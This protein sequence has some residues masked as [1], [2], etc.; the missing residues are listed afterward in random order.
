[1]DG[2]PDSPAGGEDSVRATGADDT[3]TAG[4]GNVGHVMDQRSEPD[5]VAPWVSP[6]EPIVGSVPTSARPVAVRAD[7][8]PEIPTFRLP[9]PTGPALRSPVP[10]VAPEARRRRRWPIAVAGVAAI[11]ALVGAGVIGGLVAGSG[12]DDGGRSVV[13]TADRDPISVAAPVVP[14]EGGVIGIGDTD[15]AAIARA[16]APSVVT[17]TSLDGDQPVGVG[18]GVVVSADGE[19]VTNAHVIAG[20]SDVRVR[21]QGATEPRDATVI[22][23]DPANDVALIRIDPADLDEPLAPA[24][25][26]EPGSLAVGQPVVAIGY[27]LGLDGGPSVT[28]GIVSALQRTIITPEGALDGLVQ[29]DAAISSG[30]S[31][32]PLVDATGAVV[33]INTAVLRGDSTTAANNVGFAISVD[34]LLP[35]L[36]RLRSGAEP[37]EPGF[38]GV[39]LADRVDGGTGAL[40]TEVTPGTP[41]DE[42]GAEVGDLVIAV[43]GVGVAGQAAFIAE[44]RDRVPGTAF[45][46]TVLRDGERRTLTATLVDRPAE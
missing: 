35:L 37:L 14:G 34:E 32:G 22:A 2:A 9:P 25:F 27:A 13:V 30:N 8:A 28:A 33:G 17:I 43:D 10:F 39:G 36:D 12:S 15:V 26:A 3:S 1:M 6:G 46:I 29:T 16:V 40:I 11:G 18:T 38:F 4:C 5:D 45:E 24:V 19:I 20:A 7:A 31:G 42:A 44:I 23:S 41:A 21:L